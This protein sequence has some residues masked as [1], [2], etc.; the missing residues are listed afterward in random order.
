MS[1]TGPDENEAATASRPP[2]EDG[3]QEVD[4]GAS[5]ETDQGPGDAEAPAAGV[6][7]RERN[8]APEPNEPA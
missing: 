5:S 3:R 1:T 8:E 4:D 6:V 7:D 2:A